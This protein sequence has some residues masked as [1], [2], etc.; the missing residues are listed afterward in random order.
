M[1]PIAASTAKTT[2][3]QR[4][5]AKQKGHVY[6]KNEHASEHAAAAQRRAATA[7]HSGL[8]AVITTTKTS[9]VRLVRLVTSI[10]TITSKSAIKPLAG[11]R[12]VAVLLDETTLLQDAN[13]DDESHM[14]TCRE[15]LSCIAFQVSDCSINLAT[16]CPTNGCVGPGLGF[17]HVN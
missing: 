10:R 2:T 5:N 17:S 3:L 14:F 11:A 7:D 12:A 13:E 8:S 15:Q 16:D 4:L 1:P 6:A 9:D